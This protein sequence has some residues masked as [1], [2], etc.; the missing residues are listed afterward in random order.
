[1]LSLVAEVLAD[2]HFLDLVELQWTEL[3]PDLIL[4][5]RPSPRMYAELACG[6][7]WGSK[8]YVLGGSLPTESTSPIGA[9]IQGCKQAS[10]KEDI[11]EVT[12]THL[13]AVFTTRVSRA[14]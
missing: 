8:L 3:R 9:P 14:R 6:A 5:Q 13:P 1:M 7:G 12:S 2:L 11:A 4:G 10:I